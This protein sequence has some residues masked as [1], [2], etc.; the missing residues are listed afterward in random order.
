MGW[1][2]ASVFCGIEVFVGIGM[3]ISASKD[4]MS[5]VIISLIVT[6][7]F[8]YLSYCFMKKYKKYKSNKGGSNK[9]DVSFD[10]TETNNVPIKKKPKGYRCLTAV[11]GFLIFAAILGAIFGSGDKQIAKP[12]KVLSEENTKTQALEF[13]ERAWND[14]LVMYKNHNDFMAA[15]GHYSDG[16]ISDVDFYDYCKNIEKISAEAS[17]NFEYGVTKDEKEYLAT[18]EVWALAHQQAAKDLMKYMDSMQTKDLSKAKENV[19]RAQE[20]AITIAKN[21]VVLLK[22]IG[23]TEDEINKKI[24]EGMAQIENLDK[25]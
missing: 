2:I 16:N 9:N 24:D 18:F 23:L 5:E 3:T 20:A 7:F 11:V 8:G 15:L 13:D 22:N 14:Y 19:E 1:L 25:E 12:E 21:R 4:S 6:A 17:L 10:D